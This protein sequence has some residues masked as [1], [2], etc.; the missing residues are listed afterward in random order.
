MIQE[1]SESRVDFVPTTAKPE[2]TMPPDLNKET[3]DSVDDI[4]TTTLPRSQFN[5]ILSSYDKT[6]G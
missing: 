3:Y 4:Q 5:V 2:P 1:Q 6:I